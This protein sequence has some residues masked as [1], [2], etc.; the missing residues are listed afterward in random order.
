MRKA[1]LLGLIGAL[2]IA[3]TAYAATTVTNVYTV[4]GTIK[5]AKSGTKA[6]PVPIGGHV[7]YAISTTPPGY[8]PN[9]LKTLELRVQGITENTDAFPPCGSARLNDVSEGPSTC[10]K[11]SLFGTGYL[12]ADVTTFGNQKP[13][14]V[15]TCRAEL[16]IYNGG[17][18]T[19]TFY[20][21]KGTPPAG[22]TECPLPRNEAFVAPLTHTAK[23]LVVTATFPQDL[24]HP[25][26]AGQT[27]DVAVVSSSV[28]IS[29]VSKTVKEGKG[30]KRHKV[31]I[32][33]FAS[34]LCPANHKRQVALTFVPESG[35][36]RTVTRLVA[37]HY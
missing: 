28:N 17:D 26:V 15:L 2:G 19:L 27:F 36:S 13:P 14:F 24:R 22:Q 23:G 29:T 33:L 25:T 20:V 5:P 9:L 18:H 6:H 21:Y 30:K 31:T 3:A 35:N 8:R 16:S 7:D 1:L 12:T 10:P 37:C 11:G 4:H 34:T 32:G